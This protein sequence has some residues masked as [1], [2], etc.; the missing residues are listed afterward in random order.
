[1]ARADRAQAGR[2]SCRGATTP[3]FPTTGSTKTAATLP[4]TAAKHAS[5]LARSL[6]S[7]TSV[8]RAVA[9]VTPGLSGRPRV[10]TPEPALIRNES[11]W[12]W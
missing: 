9:S 12:P 7:A 8:S 5:T 4:S 6:N 2:K 3:M 10:A 11:P 1:M